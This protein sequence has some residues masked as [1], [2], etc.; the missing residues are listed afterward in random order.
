MY[1]FKNIVGIHV[2]LHV[3]LAIHLSLCWRGIV[4]CGISL[5]ITFFL[6]LKINEN[7]LIESCDLGCFLLKH[8]QLKNIGNI[9]LIL[10]TLI[11]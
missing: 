11:Q 5:W 8:I 2:K 10:L 1:P 7:P 9:L 3:K 6:L 4:Y